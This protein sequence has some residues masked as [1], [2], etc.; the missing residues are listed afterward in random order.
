MAMMAMSDPIRLL[1]VD[2]HPVV[3]DG[4]RGQLR[5]QSAFDVVA[6][7]GS[8]DEALAVLHRRDIDVVITDLRMPGI[9]GLELIAQIRQRFPGLEILVLTTYDTDADVHAALAAGARSYLLKDTERSRLYEAITATARGR[10]VLSPSVR[11]TAA[12][13]AAKALSVREREVLALVAAGR[14]NARIGMELFVGEATV[15]THLHHIYAK[16]GAADRA[17]AVAIGYQRG[18]L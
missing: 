5:T 16:L 10:T 12:E 3:R 6:E 7:A 13:P 8:A 2:D 9:D 15:K 4:L 11:A 18:L 1:L 17:A 14:T